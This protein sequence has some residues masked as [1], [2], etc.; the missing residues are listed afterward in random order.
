MIEF[1]RQ[2]EFAALLHSEFLLLPK[3][4]GLSK[5]KEI[6]F[7]EN[8]TT[9]SILNALQ[10]SDSNTLNSDPH[11]ESENRKIHIQL[12]HNYEDELYRYLF[13]VDNTAPIYHYTSWTNCFKIVESQRLRLGCISGMI[14]RSEI[15][16]FEKLFNH[17]LKEPLHHMR[18]RYINE[19]FILSCST[20]PD[21]LNSWRLF[22]DNG[23][24]VNIQFKIVENSNS[25]YKILIG[26]VLYG[27]DLA[28]FIRKLKKKIMNF[29]IEFNLRRLYLW[30]NFLK[31]SA[32]AD[33][34]EVRLLFFNNEQKGATLIPTY[35]INRFGI[36]SSYVDF[37]F[38][39][40]IPVSIAGIKFG[41]KSTEVELNEVQLKHYLNLK[42]ISSYLISHSGITHYR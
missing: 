26:K 11:Q 40:D 36:L 1:P 3:I 18:I 39:N 7:K 29:N 35:Y 20:K 27:S 41:C 13:L 31:D 5:Q 37:S 32:Y 4:F 23:T 14:D 19:R 22:G 17:E 10:F 38:G 6:T 12:E 16:F 42:G 30:K 2:N 9:Q 8:I 34:N 33:E 21:N 28:T 24:G 15:D 25:P